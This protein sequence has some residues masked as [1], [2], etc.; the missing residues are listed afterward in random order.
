M[1]QTTPAWIVLA[2]LLRPQG[3]KGEVLAELFTDFPERFEEQ[4]RVFLAP[5]G[6][7]GEESEARA[8]EVVAF[9]LPVGKNQGR[10]VLQLSGI[11]TISD[12]EAVAGLDVLVPREERL[13]LD[14]DSVYI[15]ELIGCTVYDGAAAVGVV[16]DVQFA[17]TAD[18]AR[19]LT[20]AAPLLE[21][22]SL[23]GDEILIPFAKAFLLAVDTEAKRIEMKLPDGLVEVN[24]SSGDES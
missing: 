14:D 10:V 2:H 4:T 5:S 15:S 24:R 19:R 12:A 21:V 1:T 6:F 20:D 8:I 17:T 18:G 11:E 7:E 13:P 9:W 16:E 23:A 3:R 22:R